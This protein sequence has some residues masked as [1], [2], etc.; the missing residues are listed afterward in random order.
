MLKWAIPI[1]P[2]KTLS[3]LMSALYQKICLKKV[4]QLQTNEYI[5]FR[6]RSSFNTFPFDL[7]VFKNSKNAVQ[8]KKEA[9][10]QGSPNDISNKYLLPVNKMKR[11]RYASHHIYDVELASPNLVISDMKLYI[12]LGAGVENFQYKMIVKIFGGENNEL[13][14]FNTYEE[15]I[16]I[17]FA[18]LTKAT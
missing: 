6:S 3:H 2:E 17:Q 10:T 4:P 7:T 9:L 12:G 13:L 14:F 8:A 11:V 15:Q 5:Q 18:H 1:N 16:F